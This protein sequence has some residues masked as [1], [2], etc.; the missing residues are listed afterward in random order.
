M[1][2]ITDIGTIITEMY[3]DATYLLSSKFHANLQSVLKDTT[4]FPLIILDNEL[5]KNAEIKK[6]NNTIKDTRIVISVLKLDDLDNTDLQS[7]TLR[8]SC[9]SIAD[10]IAAVI[11]QLIPVRPRDNQKYILTPLFHV[12]STNLTGVA[13]EMR[14]NYNEL[15]RF[16]FTRVIDEVETDADINTFLGYAGG[17]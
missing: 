5:S 11:Y 4:D 8:Q 9:E 7:E 13:L 12:F 3:P 17:N 6:N 10:R 14:V 2:L 16:Q 1:S 15:T